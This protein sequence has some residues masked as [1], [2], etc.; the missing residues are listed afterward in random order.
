MLHLLDSAEAPIV[1][2]TTDTF[3]EHWRGRKYLV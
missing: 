2:E 1:H 3:A